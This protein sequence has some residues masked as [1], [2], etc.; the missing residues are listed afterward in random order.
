MS[1]QNSGGKPQQRNH[2]YSP[3]YLEFLHRSPSGSPRDDAEVVRA[4][5]ALAAARRRAAAKSPSRKSRSSRH[6]AKKQ[7]KQKGKH[8]VHAPS[9]GEEESKG[10]ARLLDTDKVL[11]RPL[12]QN[13]SYQNLGQLPLQKGM[14][15]DSTSK[16]LKQTVPKE[17]GSPI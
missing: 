11:K 17:F 8:S 3:R 15:Y 16:H 13:L 4:E 10:S 12:P 6:S 7:N 1:P 14:S 9:Q 2:S 5:A